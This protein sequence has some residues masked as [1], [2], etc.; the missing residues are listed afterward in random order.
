M[1][2]LTDGSALKKIAAAIEKA[3]TALIFPHISVDGD[4]LGSSV[5]LCRAMRKQGKDVWIQIEDA[6]P[7]NLKFM[8]K[9]YTTAD[10][11]RI[12]A[13]D[14]CI[15]LDCGETGRFPKRKE[16]FFSGGMTV[17]IDHHFTTEPFADLNYIDA[18][19]AATAEIVYALLG[20][21]GAEID[22]ETAEAIYTGIV[23]DTGRFGYSNTT[24]KTHLIAAELLDLG[25]DPSK[26]AVLLFQSVR[27]EKLALNSKVMDTLEIFAEGKGAIAVMTRKMLTETG[28]EADE[29]EG[30]VEQLRNI[31]GV[32][33]AGLVKEINFRQVKVSL[34][35]KNGYGVSELA[36]AFGGGGHIRAAGY[37]AAAV[38][39]EAAAELKAEIEKLLKKNPE[40]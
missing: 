33:V 23:T 39:K 18:D 12:A 40:A 9:G 13:A 17:C 36:S 38:P 32:E 30:I 5:A 3:K 4:A 28:A 29:S 10:S 1:N 24:K 7:E 15:A 37:I 11:D 22:A 31:R 8:D 26:I 16:K 27:R 35:A 25:A 21:L 19:A 20:E 34:R 14:L 2:G 6:I